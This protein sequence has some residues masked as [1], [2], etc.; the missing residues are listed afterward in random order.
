MLWI[1]VIHIDIAVQNS[2]STASA[3][4]VCRRA[5]KD[6]HLFERME[7]YGPREDGALRPTGGWALRPTGGWGTRAHGRMGHYGPREVPHLYGCLDYEVW[8]VTNKAGNQR[9]QLNQAKG[10]RCERSTENLPSQMRSS[11]GITLNNRC[12]SELKMPAPRTSSNEPLS[13]QARAIITELSHVLSRNHTANF[14]DLNSAEQLNDNVDVDAH[15]EQPKRS[16]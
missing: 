11:T 6:R 15:R 1:I 10:V 8:Q 9:R 7:H 2:D 4:V 16:K 12:T 5:Y 13:A 3:E 14:F